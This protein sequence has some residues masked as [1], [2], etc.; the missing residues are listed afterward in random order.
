MDISKSYHSS[1]VVFLIIQV[2]AILFC[3]VILHLE[4]NANITY[5]MKNVGSGGF[6]CIPLT[7]TIYYQHLT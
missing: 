3:Y 1:G 4:M 5:E 6:N 7:T 2:I